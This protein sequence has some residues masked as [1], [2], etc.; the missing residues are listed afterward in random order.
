M[1]DIIRRETVYRTSVMDGRVIEHEAPVVKCRCGDEVVCD[2]FTNTC[3]ECGSDFNGSGQLLA[4]RSQ[5]GEETGESVSD[6]L[7]A[8]SDVEPYGADW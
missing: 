8:D 5:W 3:Y 6:I 1:T 7:A 4:D 2:R